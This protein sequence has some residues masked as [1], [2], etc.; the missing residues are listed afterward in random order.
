MINKTKG[1]N[2]KSERGFYKPKSYRFSA[3]THNTLARL[4]KGIGSHEKLQ[5]IFIKLYKIYGQDN[6]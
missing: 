2:K 3:E 5:K 4:S 6:K 1:K